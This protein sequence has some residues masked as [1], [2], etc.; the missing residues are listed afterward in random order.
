MVIHS[1]IVPTSPAPA[2]PIKN[3]LPPEQESRES[4]WFPA[5]AQSRAIQ[6]A[7]DSLG[8]MQV[9]SSVAATGG[10]GYTARLF[11][12]TWGTA[13]GG[14]AAAVG[15]ITVATSS[16]LQGPGRTRGLVSGSLGIAAGLSTMVATLGISPML[17]AMSSAILVAGKIAYEEWTRPGGGRSAASHGGEGP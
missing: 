5:R 13:F 15:G 11:S 6:A 2:P 8:G 1:S 9:F 17:G 16:G 4:D 12:L 14:V 3:E 10:L 7:S